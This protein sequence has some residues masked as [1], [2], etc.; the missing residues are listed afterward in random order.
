MRWV[1]PISLPEE[2]I[3]HIIE[4]I[5]VDPTIA[6]ILLQRNIHSFEEA[7]D[8]FNPD[9]HLLHDPMLM[10]GMGIAV[11]K[12]LQTIQ[13][14]KRILVYGDYDVDGTTSVALLYSYL[15]SIDGDILTYV[16][17]RYTEG[18][19]ISI[20]GIDYAK[21]EKVALIIAIDCGIRAIEQVKYAKDLG[22]DFIICDHHL[23]AETLPDA[24]AILNPKQANCS[25]PYKELCACGVGFK[26]LQ[27]IQA[28]LEKNIEEL[29]TYLDLVAIAIAADIVPIT[30]ENRILAAKGLEYLNKQE[31]RIGIQAILE[32]CKIENQN[33]SLSDLVFKIAPRINAAGRMKHA[34]HSVDLL[35]EK[36][37]NTAKSIASNIENFNRNRRDIDSN[38]TKEALSQIEEQQEMKNSSTVVYHENW[39]KGVLGIV[40]SRLIETHY[41]PTIVFGKGDNLLT[42]SARSVKGF[43]IY[44]AI[45]ECA[46]LL[47]KF[48]GHKYAAGLSLL[49]ENFPAFKQKFEAI[50]KESINSDSLE[51]AIQI[52][53]E[54]DLKDLIAESN[55]KFPK[56]YRILKRMQP[57]GPGNANPVFITRNVKDRGSR[58]V[59]KEGEHLKLQIS[60]NSS[61][62][63]FIGIGFGMGEKLNKINKDNFDVLYTLEENYW[64]GN[65]SL[66]LRIKD[67]R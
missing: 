32:T 38:I 49:P 42:A 27:A 10:K 53:A 54:L 67:I 13:E 23:P 66:Q 40:A 33:L 55:A 9:I 60:D 8:F 61:N 31:K 62:Q 14:G 57:F 30:G 34:H 12:I 35:I 29:Y 59:G 46:S 47:E 28:R 6:R 39:H 19:G 45:N 22:V 43:N 63:V 11:A 56:L 50:V 65:T 15:T 26:L 7:R 58:K 48:G 18:Y 2:G 41:R 25:Y 5:G 64:N 1:E 37:R 4:K 21:R 16:P 20:Q 51:P 24:V 3:Q 52:E 17:D 44:E 36:D